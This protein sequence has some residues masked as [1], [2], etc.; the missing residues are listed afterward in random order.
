MGMGLGRS[1]RH[2]NIWSILSLIIILLILVP[3]LNI[4]VN[5]F[6]EPNDTWDHIK[7]YLLKDYTIN[8]LTLVIFT[9]LFATI[10][11]TSLA[12]LVSV[13]DFP[14]RNFFK[15]T[16]ILPLAIPPYIAAYT[17]NGLLSYTGAIQSFLRNNFDIYVNQKYFD[18]MSMQGT[19]FIF[20]MFLFPYV[21]TITRGFMSKQSADLIENARLLGK[22]PTSIFFRI[23]LP[24]SRVAIIGGVSLVVL[25][26]LN[27]YGVVNYYGIQTFS[28]AIFTSWFGMGDIDSAIRLA[29]I[30]MIIVFIIL[31]S[32]KM[33]RGRKK[34]NYTTTK[35]R[36]IRPYELKGMK[37]WLAFLYAGL[38]LMISFIIPVI[39]LMDWA[40]LSYRKVL[41]SEFFS[42]ALNSVLVALIASFIMVVIALIVANNNRLSH[43][44]LSKIYGRITTLGYSIPGAVIAIGVMVFFINIDHRLYWLY[45]LVDSNSGKLVLSTSVVMLIF[46]YV[47]RFL[48]IG[49]NA[50]DSGFE[51]IGITFHE[52]ARTLGKN[53]IET[54]FK[55]DLKMISPAVLGGFLLVFIETLKELP[56]TLLLRPFNFNTLATKSYEY[57]NDEMI[58]EAAVPSLL[59]VLISFIAIYM[60]NKISQRKGA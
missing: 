27:D 8:S 31:F 49:Y 14:L 7:T 13:Y 50:V 57:A 21:Y 43:N 6:N 23:V 35:V 17:Y 60:Y 51:K 44:L 53:S 19:I 42:L 15:W 45:Q 58:H 54:F 22:S 10:I 25:E 41:D 46:A 37:A 18:I 33:L 47:V 16:L 5:I 36:P 24:L 30:L 12:W 34:Y 3:N 9:G 4:F 32:E 29:A 59:I 52:A 11:G 38:I 56:L 48:G 2:I 40:L 39:Q 1:K 28:T 20:T 26:V 55:V